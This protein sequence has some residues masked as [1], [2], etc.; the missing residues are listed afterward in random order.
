MKNDV[1]L[2]VN[3]VSGK[4]QY[5]SALHHVLRELAGA[6]HAAT[7]YFTTKAG[8]ANEYARLYAPDYD[9]LLCLGGDGTVSGAIDGLMRTENPPPM[10]YIPIGTANDM[11]SN[12]KL[13]RNPEKAVR[14][15][16]RGK[17]HLIDVGR[18]NDRHFAYIAAFGAFTDVAYSTPQ[19]NKNMLGHLAYVLEGL[20]DLP[21]ISAVHAVVEHDGGREEGRYIFG[22]VVNSM[23]V[24]GMVKLD[25][26][27]VGLSD[28]YFEAMLIKEPKKI[29]DTNSILRGILRQDYDP[30]HITFIHTRKINFSFD[31]SVSWT[32]DGEDGGSWQYAEAENLHKAIKLIVP[33]GFRSD[34][35]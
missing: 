12:F 16:L 30:E 11:A 13:D 8:D 29:T 35:G 2:I 21:K 1:M 31:E 20:A 10:G 15:I 32:L 7:V 6:G 5:S 24:A 9:M 27:D 23:S 33:E 26:V 4:G 25:K 19:S 34:D 14:S 17:E 18:F 3:P 22:A 28:G